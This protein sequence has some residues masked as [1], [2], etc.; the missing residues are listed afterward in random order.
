M[1]LARVLKKVLEGLRAQA[2]PLPSGAN[3][4][5]STLYW[6]QSTAG[7]AAEA[8]ASSSVYVA[9]MAQLALLHRVGCNHLEVLEQP[10]PDSV[11]EAFLFEVPPTEA[12][13]E[14]VGFHRGVWMKRDRLVTL[15]S[16]ADR[17]GSSAR[18]AL[19]QI[20]WWGLGL[21]VPTSPQLDRSLNRTSLG[22]PSSRTP[23]CSSCPRAWVTCHGTY[24]QRCNS[25]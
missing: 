19:A 20:P 24:R 9:S 16:I 4:L 6:L 10:V 8:F 25:K 2:P 13:A 1:E 5:R 23:L 17:L 18:G 14:V 11:A 3:S 21:H 12:R 15:Q 22:C 7:A